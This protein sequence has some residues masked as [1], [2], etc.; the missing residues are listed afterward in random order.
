MGGRKKDRRWR[1]EVLQED[2]EAS[3]LDCCVLCLLK[4]KSETEPKTKI[5]D[6]TL[7]HGNGESQRF[8]ESRMA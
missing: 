5:F 8:R 3:N 7:N 4:V 6:D 1:L 2:S